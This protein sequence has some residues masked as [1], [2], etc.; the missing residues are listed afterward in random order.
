MGQWPDEMTHRYLIEDIR[1]K[2]S[3]DHTD[4]AALNFINPSAPY[5]FRRHFRQGLR[6]HIMEILDPP[7]VLVEQTGILKEGI[8]WFPKA[9]PRRMFRIFRRRL[10]SLADAL[11][12]IARVKLVE[13]YLAPDFMATSTECIVEYHGPDGPDLLLCG[14]QEYARGEII[15]PWTILDAVDL[16]AVLYETFRNRGVKLT[17]PRD[18]WMRTVRQ[19]GARFIEYIKRMITEVKH[20]PDLAGT[21]NL[22][23]TGEGNIRLVDINNISPVAFEEAV[24]LDEQGYP[25]C[26]KSVE[27]L[28]LLE[29]KILG[30]PVDK[31]ENVYRWFLDPHRRKVVRA[32]EDLFLKQKTAG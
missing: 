12:E 28:G 24:R 13:R 16:P 11:K 19:S 17:L 31:D 10:P 25:V 26:D 27:A 2:A 3:L 21:G 9:V 5:V 29:A 32:K 1:D 20:I 15:D 22:I 4:V 18:E 8:R 23:I 7:D 30:R 6:S 14:F